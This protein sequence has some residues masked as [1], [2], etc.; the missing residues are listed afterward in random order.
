MLCFNCREDELEGSADTAV[1][2]VGD[3]NGPGDRQQS[4]ERCGSVLTGP[5]LTDS[6]DRKLAQ[7]ESFGLAGRGQPVL[8]PKGTSPA[9]GT[10]EK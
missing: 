3:S 4:C 1:L 8:E 5:E 10:P 9:G 7:L 6:T 2:D